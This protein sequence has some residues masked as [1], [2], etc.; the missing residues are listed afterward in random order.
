MGQMK[1]KKI[2]FIGL[3]SM[4]RPMA[5][6]IVKADYPV[7]VFDVCEGPLVAL[8]EMGARIAGNTREV[9]EGSDTVV[10]MVPGYSQMKEAVLPPDGVL[11]GMSRDSTLIITSTLSPAEVMAVEK[12]AR[13]L[14]VSLIDSP[15]SGGYARA[16]EGT[17]TF[18]VG[19]DD[20]VV[21][22]NRAILE[23]MGTNV[24]HVGKVGQGQAVKLINQMLV[25]AN[26]MSVAEALVMA[27]KLDLDL[28]SVV[29]VVGK[30]GGDSFVLQTMAPAMIARDFKP[31]A[32]VS[33]F[34]KDTGII[35]DTA[36]ELNVPLLVAGMAYNIIRMADARGFG[37]KD[38]SSVI[39]VFE[40][41]AGI[42][43]GE[44]E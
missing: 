38:I 9:G 6:N 14:G 36:R 25:S 1:S 11:S 35:M 18:M 39:K 37:Q 15:V 23:V 27:K 44:G 17:L 16:A 19:G 13:Q 22:R 41:L 4:G 29:D 31:R 32:A 12:A 30:S 26:I 40:A 20:E 34:I 28:A 7:K 10:V 21:S 3:G 42:S 24:F 2:G 5:A 8:G 43:G 33:I